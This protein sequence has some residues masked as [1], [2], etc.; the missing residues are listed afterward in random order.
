[1]PIKTTITYRAEEC[2][3]SGA[4]YQQYWRRVGNMSSRL[5]VVQ[6]NLDNRSRQVVYYRTRYHTRIL[7]RTIELTTDENR[8]MVKKILTEEVIEA[9][10]A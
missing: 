9:N 5:D 10:Y 6:G 1:M 8:R 4:T 3:V 7:K 2:N